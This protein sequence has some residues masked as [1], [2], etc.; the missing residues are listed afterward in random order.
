MS[1]LISKTINTLA[2]IHPYWWP[3]VPSLPQCS[4]TR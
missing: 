4:S 1:S 3:G 2:A